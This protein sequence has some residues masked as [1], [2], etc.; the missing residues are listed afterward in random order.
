MG[1][2][3]DSRPSI[4]G[5]ASF[6]AWAPAGRRRETTTAA[7]ALWS[8]ARGSRTSPSIARAPR[9]TSPASTVGERRQADGRCP[10]LWATPLSRVGV[11][12]RTTAIATAS[13]RLTLRARV[14]TTAER[15][16]RSASVAGPLTPC[17]LVIAVP[18]GVPP[19]SGLPS[20]GCASPSTGPL[21]RWRLRAAAGNS[22]AGAGS[23]VRTGEDPGG[24]SGAGT[25]VGSATGAGLGVGS[26][27]GGAGEGAGAGAGAAG[28]EGEGT[29]AAGGG[30]AGEESCDG[31]AGLGGGAGDGVGAGEGVGAGA[32]GAVAAAE[33]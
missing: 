1:T 16:C 12:L 23:N 4:I 27:A 17:A 7:P 5:S 25:G 30:G 26:V 31:G 28:G 2:R 32:G 6:A 20:L 18:L 33:R 11:R 8:R 24:D 15:S 21:G 29:V 22:S 9:T 14:A 3:C 10:G 13:P 19:D